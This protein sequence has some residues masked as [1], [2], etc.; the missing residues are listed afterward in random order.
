MSGTNPRISNF[1]S[2][3]SRLRMPD[4]DSMGTYV[5]KSFGTGSAQTERFLDKFETV[6]AQLECGMAVG[7]SSVGHQKA[8]VDGAVVGKEMAVACD[9]REKQPQKLKRPAENLTTGTLFDLESHL[10]AAR[11]KTRRD[12]DADLVTVV[13]NFNEGQCLLHMRPEFSATESL[14]TDNAAD[15][16]TDLSPLPLDQ[17]DSNCA[18]RLGTLI[19]ETIEQHVDIKKLEHT[20]KV[21]SSRL[22]HGAAKTSEREIVRRQQPILISTVPR[23]P[24][25]LLDRVQWT[26]TDTNSAPMVACSEWSFAA[27]NCYGSNLHSSESIQPRQTSAISR[28]E[29]KL[30]SVV[31]VGSGA[32]LTSTLDETRMKSHGT[33][34]SSTKDNQFDLRYVFT[35]EV[36]IFV[37]VYSFCA[38]FI[39]IN[40]PLGNLNSGC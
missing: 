8:T 33:S 39:N 27:A 36:Q 30:K 16:I 1:L 2:Q 38:N 7:E 21:V 26:N 10:D 19:A 35:A 29:N 23:P 37:L 6:S 40:N 24:A 32:H 5:K 4:S 13:R 15:S 34:G 25:N 11:K 12:F 17:S 31:K 3:L 28:G 22:R 14:S 18:V 9:L 20:A